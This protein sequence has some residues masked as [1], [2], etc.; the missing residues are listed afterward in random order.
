VLQNDFERWSEEHFSE[1]ARQCGILIQ[2][3]AP[4]ESNLAHYWPIGSSL[5]TFATQSALSDALPHDGR[6]SLSAQSGNGAIMLHAISAPL[7]AAVDYRRAQRRLFYRPGQHRAG[8][9]VLLLRG[10]AG[11]QTAAKLL[12]SDEAPRMAVNFAKL[13]L[14]LSKP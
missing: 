11:R 4:S 12:T 3:S 5:A 7:P 14:R 6:A 1:I 8:A 10:R 9:R 13:P 2:E